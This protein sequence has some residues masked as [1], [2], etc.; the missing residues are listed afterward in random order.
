[1][2]SRTWPS[3]SRLLYTQSLGSAPS[4][5]FLECVSDGHADVER[6]DQERSRGAL[7]A[8]DHAGDDADAAERRVVLGGQLGSDA[9]K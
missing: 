1:M 8:V 9:M 3:E 6:A 4:A 2:R 7:F 5:V